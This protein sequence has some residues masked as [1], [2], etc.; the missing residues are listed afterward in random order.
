[1]GDVILLTGA[2]GQIGTALVPRLVRDPAARV[3]ALVRARDA[4]HLDARRRELAERTG[5]PLERVELVRGDVTLPGL[6]LSPEDR[7]RVESEVTAILHAAASVRF[8]LPPQQAAADNLGATQSVLELA[9]ALH[10]RGRLTRLDHVST[11]YV[12]GTTRAR[13]RETDLDVGQGFRNSYEWSKQQS[14]LK[15]QEARARGLPVSIH[16]PSIVVGESGTGRTRAFNVLYW[17]LKLYVRGWWRTFPGEPSTLV[18]IVPVDW[19]AEA[20]VHI[21]A[22]PDTLGKTFH[23]AAGEDA[24]PVSELAARIAQITGGPPVRYIDQRLYK[25]FGRPL[26]TPFLALTRRGRAIL[27]GGEA[28]MPYFVGNPLFDTTH[29]RAALGPAGGPPP[30]LEYLER[31]VRFATEEDFGDA[32]RSAS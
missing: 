6:G 4:A 29:A 32:S 18:D 17:P 21:R 24:R 8:D 7:A 25:R 28:Y 13:F 12:A 2:T 19:V 5:A 1:M 3:L 26:V 10:R 15:V 20:M 30:I 23:L 9:E 27:R 22:R 14:E 31:I 11:A 16:R